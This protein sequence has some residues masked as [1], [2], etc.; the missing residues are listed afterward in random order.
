MVASINRTMKSDSVA[1]RAHAYT[2][3]YRVQGF[4]YHEV[5]MLAIRA[6]SIRT[7]MSNALM[8]ARP[9]ISRVH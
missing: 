7:S 2:L 3:K 1:N 8:K 6:S 9:A 4:Q 5:K